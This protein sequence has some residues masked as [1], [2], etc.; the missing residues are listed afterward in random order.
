MRM[1]GVIESK[2]QQLTF[3]N[4]ATM[5]SNWP[6]TASSPLMIFISTL[7]P[8]SARLLLRLLLSLGSAEEG[9]VVSAFLSPA[10]RRPAAGAG[11]AADRPDESA[12][13]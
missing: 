12:A 3:M 7:P 8:A 2:Q 6:A 5:K 4:R 10:R 11:G 1:Q 13:A 9:S